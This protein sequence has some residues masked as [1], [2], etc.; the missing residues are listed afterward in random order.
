MVERTPRLRTDQYLLVGLTQH[1]AVDAGEPF[2]LDLGAKPLLDRLVGART[3]VEIDQFARAFAQAMADIVARDDQV[4]AARVLAA[5]DDMGVGMPGV[6]V[7]DRHPIE[8][9]PQV[10]LDPGHEPPRQRLEVIIFHAVLGADDDA[11]LLAVDLRRIQPGASVHCVAVGVVELP[12]PALARRA[13]TLDI[14]KMRLG[15]LEA[16]A[17]E[18]DGP[19]L[20]DDA[21]PS[22]RGVAVAR[23][24]DA[25]DPGTAPDPAAGE[26]RPA[27]QTRRATARKIGGGDHAR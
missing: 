27:G 17:A 8:R 12:A 25:A 4:P 22:E 7:I 5:D 24:Q 21:A 23:R 10:L 18:F 16:L 11:E 15:A 14:A 9:R 20:D 3:K 2:L 13:V 6:I 19:G 1:R 26:R